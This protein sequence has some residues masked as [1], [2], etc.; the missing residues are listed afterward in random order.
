MNLAFIFGTSCIRSYSFL[1]FFIQ[2]THKF[3]FYYSIT[4]Q[5]IKLLKKYTCGIYVILNYLIII[6][7]KSITIGKKLLYTN[8]FR[9]IS[10]ENVIIYTCKNLVFL[11]FCITNSFILYHI[12]NEKNSLIICVA[13]CYFFYGLLCFVKFLIETNSYLLKLQECEYQV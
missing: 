10:T 5:N 9:S 8:N 12:W 13:I 7:S 6:F 11:S 3:C 4:Q 2:N 1:S